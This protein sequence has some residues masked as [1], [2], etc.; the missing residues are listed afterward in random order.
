MKN[1]KAEIF[2]GIDVSKDSF[3]LAFFPKHKSQTFLY[4]DQHLKDFVRLLKQVAPHLVVLEATGGYEKKIFQKLKDAQIPV[5]IVNPK[6]VRDFAK[7]IGYLA[8]TDKI[9]AFVLA[10]Y[11]SL[12]RKGSLKMEADDELRSLKRRRDQVVKMLVEE[13]NR[14]KQAGDL[15]RARIKKHIEVLEEEKEELTKEIEEKLKKAPK[16]SD[17]SKKVDLLVSIPGVNLI[18]AL[19]VLLEM[20]ELG[21]VN[22]KEIAALAGLA[23]FNRDSG[24]FRGRRGIW[25]GR[26]KV[27]QALY[28]AVLAGLRWNGKMREF[29]TR[30]TEEGKKAGKVALTACMRKLLTI[31]NQILKNGTPW[32]EIP[33]KA[34]P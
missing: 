8:K 16:Y 7:S 29:F 21:K 13:K 14:L 34:N 32:E 22:R 11:A 28:M 10:R 20:P 15:V 3:D 17:L 5:L 6:R 24:Q 18:T 31:M 33:A 1:S 26:K 2:I 27:R 19:S 12:I 4:D 25:G 23:P 30:L 9:D